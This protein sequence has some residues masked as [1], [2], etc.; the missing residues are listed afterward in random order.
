MKSNSH[1]TIGCPK[2]FSAIELIV[3]VAIIGTLVAIAMPPFIQWRENLQYR[4]AARS[5]ASILRQA[6][7]LAITT[8]LEQ[9]V[10]FNPAVQGFG[11][12]TGDRANNANFAGA[13]T[14][15]T[16]IPS[17]VKISPITTIMFAPNG[18]SPSARHGADPGSLRHCTLLCYG[19]PSRQDNSNPIK[20][21]SLLS[22]YSSSSFPHSASANI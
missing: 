15:W 1:T 8:N 5:A 18:T 4:T 16:T 7:N 21:V 20:V 3:V 17:T 6:K 11:I 13:P 12:Q 22:C 2:G 9:Q 10:V 14:N 19:D